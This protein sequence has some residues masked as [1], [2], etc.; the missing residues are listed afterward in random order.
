MIPFALRI[1][2]NL[3][4]TWALIRT[5]FN[6]LPGN[7]TDYLTHDAL[8]DNTA[9]KQS[10]ILSLPEKTS[11]YHETPVLNLLLPAVFRTLLLGGV[12]FLLALFF[13]LSMLY[14]AF[15][16][17]NTLSALQKISLFFSSFPLI[18]LGPLTLLIFSVWI[19]LFAIQKSFLLAS[20]LLSW[21][22]ANLWFRAS[23]KML[24]EYRPVSSE[25]GERSRGFSEFNIFFKSLLLP[26]SGNFT[27]YLGNQ[28]GNILGGSVVIEMVFQWPG[29]GTLLIQSLNRRDLPVIESTLMVVAVFSVTANLTFKHFGKKRVEE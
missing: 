6:Y 22:L 3:C 28:L 26:I 4:L 27:Q 12:S 15:R 25:I 24:S 13:S 18:I 21:S 23:H 16:K 5:G 8:V 9:F 29:L 10:F 11:I 14:L 1:I 7:A 20:I 2:I 19:P 17:P